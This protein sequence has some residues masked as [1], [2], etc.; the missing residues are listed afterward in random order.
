MVEFIKD[1]IY[2]LNQSGKHGSNPTQDRIVMNVK[3]R[4]GNSRMEV[5][6]EEGQ[7]DQNFDGFTRV[8][9]TKIL[10]LIFVIFEY[11]AKSCYCIC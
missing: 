6:G 5:D 3:N 8:S 2:E 10:F 4:S 9:G 11:A 1:K 7:T